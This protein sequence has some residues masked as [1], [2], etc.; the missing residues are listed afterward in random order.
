MSDDFHTLRG[1][2]RMEQGEISHAM[3]DYLEMICRHT[4]SGKYLRVNRLAALLNVTPPSASKMAAKLK[5]SGMVDFEPYGIITLTTK[6][7]EL[8]EY[9]LRRHEIVSRFFCQ[10]N[11][12]QSELELAEKIE[13]Y[14]D[15][16]TVENM[17]RL[18]A[19]LEADEKSRE[20]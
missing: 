4:G 9:L 8:G 20:K 19:Q 13:H 1:Y 15:R 10:V 5:E 7:R 11:H 12:T 16:R 14:L 2:T 17:D 3:E 6:G 18:L